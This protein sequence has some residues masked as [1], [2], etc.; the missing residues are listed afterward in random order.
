VTNRSC[1]LPAGGEPDF[2]SVS[3]NIIND[4]QRG[5]LPYFVAP[6]L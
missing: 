2:R 3:V 1:R 5:K 4:Y 6:P